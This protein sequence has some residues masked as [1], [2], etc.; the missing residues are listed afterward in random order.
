MVFVIIH[1]GKSGES[2]DTLRC[3]HYMKAAA[4]RKAKLQPK[5]LQPTEHTAYFHFQRVHLQA[6][7]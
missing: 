7:Q 1:G 4:T 2:I 5:T 6:V 3:A